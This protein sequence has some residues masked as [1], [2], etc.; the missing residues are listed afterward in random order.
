MGLFLLN[1][2]I[3]ADQALAAWQVS[4]DPCIIE[5]RKLAGQ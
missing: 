2:L 5:E 1:I 3:R 4:N